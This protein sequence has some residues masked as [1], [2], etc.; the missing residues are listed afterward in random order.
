MRF[1]LL[2]SGSRGNATLIEHRQT[3]VM[4]D[5]G[6]SCRETERRM[7]R[8]DCH[9]ADLDAVVVTHEHGDVFGEFAGGI[10]PRIRCHRPA[11][12]WAG[13]CAR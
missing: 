6:F 12:Y 8:L 9:P 10:G 4:L 11:R 1:A 5:C 2:G 7:A 3:L 13:L